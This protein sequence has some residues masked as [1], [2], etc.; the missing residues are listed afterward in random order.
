M[1]SFVPRLI[2]QRFE[3]HPDVPSA[4]TAEQLTAA[5]LQCDLSGFTTLTEGLAKRGPAG[6][7]ELSRS[8]SVI[9]ERLTKLIAAHGCDVVKFAGDALLAI[10]PVAHALSPQTPTPSIAVP[11]VPMICE[12]TFLMRL[13]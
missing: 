11:P 5:L 6:A 2:A 1:A 13:V 12:T 10:W 4:P 7:E 8:L 3:S 9:F